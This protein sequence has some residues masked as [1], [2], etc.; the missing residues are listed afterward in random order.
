MGCTVR[1][2]WRRHSKHDSD[3]NWSREGQRYAKK[4]IWTVSDIDRQNV[5]KRFRM[6]LAFGIFHQRFNVRFNDRSCVDIVSMT[7][8]ITD[9]SK[10]GVM[11]RNLAEQCERWTDSRMFISVSGWYWYFRQR[12]D[13]AYPSFLSSLP[14]RNLIYTVILLAMRL[15]LRC[16]FV[17]ETITVIYWAI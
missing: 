11:P 12:M 8:I 3:Y 5:H 4:P 15:S 6:A 14:S 7:Q 10:V 1:Q 17:T 13:S 2:E 9:H 16:R